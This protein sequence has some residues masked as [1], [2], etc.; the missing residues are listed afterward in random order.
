MFGEEVGEGDHVG[1]VAPHPVEAAIAAFQMPAH[2][3]LNYG[4]QS[5]SGG[6][7]EPFGL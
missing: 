5:R 3:C 2:S 4:M 7:R 1:W 6:D